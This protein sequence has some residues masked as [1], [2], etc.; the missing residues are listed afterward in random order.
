MEEGAKNKNCLFRNKSYQ[1]HCK[2]VLEDLKSTQI[3]F[4]VLNPSY[5]KYLPRFGEAWQYLLQVHGFV[6]QE[7]NIVSGAGPVCGVNSSM[8]WELTT[9]LTSPPSALRSR[10]TSIYFYTLVKIYPNKNPIKTRHFT[11]HVTLPTER[12]RRQTYDRWQLRCLMH[13]WMVLKYCGDKGCRRAD[14][15]ENR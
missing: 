13:W 9:P 8:N 14:I 12:T 7:N 1:E 11:E 15:E 6:S 5:L 4:K 3:K 2:A 10:Q